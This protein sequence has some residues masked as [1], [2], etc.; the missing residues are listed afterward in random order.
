MQRARRKDTTQRAIQAALLACGFSVFDTSG[1]GGDFPDLVAGKHGV[2]VLIE[3]KS[4]KRVRKTASD[5]LSEGQK[6]F[7]E[8]WR[9][10]KVIVAE[11]LEDV[12]D[13]F[14]VIAGGAVVQTIEPTHFAYAGQR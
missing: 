3:V 1:V 4:P 14:A 6:R 2:T 10:S 9:G 13:A 11:R 7:R 8:R 12:L 5:G